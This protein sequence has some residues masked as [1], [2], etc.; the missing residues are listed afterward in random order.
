[1]KVQEVVFKRSRYHEWNQE[2]ECRKPILQS[3]IATVPAGVNIYRVKVS[4]FL[5]PV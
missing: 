1:M 4:V 3:P 2:E 5:C